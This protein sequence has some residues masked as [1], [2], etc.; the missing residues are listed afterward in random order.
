MESSHIR[1]PVQSLGSGLDKSE[2]FPGGGG[3]GREFSLL[4][5]VQINCRG[6]LKSL[7]GGY[8]GFFASR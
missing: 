6:T 1:H 4:Q 2:I 5:S 3:R 8:C 7:F